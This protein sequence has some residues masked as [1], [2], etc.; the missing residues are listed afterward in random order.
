MFPFGGLC[1]NLSGKHEVST[2]SAAWQSGAARVD[3]TVAG[4]AG[5]MAELST[6]TTVP[7]GQWGIEAINGRGWGDHRQAVGADARS[8]SKSRV[9]QY[10]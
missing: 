1:I 4:D 6:E 9:G 8:A 2:S 7:L 10:M 5:L 3:V